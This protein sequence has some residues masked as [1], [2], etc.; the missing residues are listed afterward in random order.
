MAEIEHF[1]DPNNKDHAKF[2]L[3]A[4]IKLPLLSAKSQET[5]RK[6]E[7]EILLKDAV[8]SKLIKN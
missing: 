8:E 5:D 1:V 4:D 7:K 6:V 3:V 2:Y